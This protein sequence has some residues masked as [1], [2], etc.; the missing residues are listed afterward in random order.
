MK[1]SKKIIGL[2]VCCAVALLSNT[3]SGSFA[4]NRDPLQRDKQLT[5][6]SDVQLVR[7]LR[8]SHV[9]NFGFEPSPA[10]LA[11]AWAQVAL[12]NGQGKFVW[13]HNLGNIGSPP[14]TSHEFYVHS[15]YTSYRSFEGY[16]EGGV[17]YWRTVRRCGSAWAN[18]EVGNATASAL[19]LKN[20]GYYGADTDQYVR[21][22]NELYAYALGNV[23][24]REAREATNE[25][26]D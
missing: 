11:M 7:A 3:A 6:L 18:F 12:E 8:D 19:Y 4:K 17:A 16:L 15:S 26:K 2:A 10:K 9:E 22:M 25:G 20:C 23:I 24:P 14:G 13:N 5:P 1:F 21:G